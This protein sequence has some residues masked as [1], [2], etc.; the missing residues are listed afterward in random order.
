MSHWRSERFACW[1]SQLPPEV[2]D[3]PISSVCLPGT[4]DRYV[5]GVGVMLMAPASF[6]GDSIDILTARN[7]MLPAAPGCC[8]VDL[9]IRLVLCVPVRLCSSAR[10]R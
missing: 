4:H 3:L 10:A 7:V 9:G 6:L 8:R 2:L 1:M 5:R